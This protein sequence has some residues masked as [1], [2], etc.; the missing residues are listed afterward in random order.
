MDFVVS[1]ESTGQRLDLFLSQ[2]TDFSRSYLQKLIKE[3]LVTV[4]GEPAKPGYRLKTGD[5]ILVTIPPPKPLEVLPEDIPL[6]IAYEDKDLIVVNKPQGMVTHPAHGHFTGTLV[7]A[8]L[9]HCKN[10]S[11]IGGILRPGIVHRLDKDTSGLLVVAKNDLAHQ[12]L[13]KQLK[14]R[15]I[16]RSYLALVHGVIRPNEGAIEAPI[17]RHLTKRKRMAVVLKPQAKKK[18]ALTYFKVLE[19]FKDYTLLEVEIKTGRTH[20]IR[21]HMAHIGHPIVGDPVYGRRKEKF[22]LPGQALHA[23]TLG[24]IHPRTGKYLEFSRPM[25]NPMA[26]VVNHLKSML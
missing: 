13:A 11:G 24:F 14:E 3:G 17:G 12:S 19:R 2:K 5:K 16:T 26:E 21:V 15:T 23:Q 6:D 22:R 8:L 4:K 1:K 18:E 10:L 20:Q 25:P 9:Y 7:N